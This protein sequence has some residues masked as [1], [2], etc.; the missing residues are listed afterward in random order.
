M[1]LM[2]ASRD[3]RFASVP[4]THVSIFPNRL[5]LRSEEGEP[6]ALEGK[7]RR[8]QTLGDTATTPRSPQGGAAQETRERERQQERTS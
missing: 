1:S 7:E 2:A 5:F 6:P 8:L 4:V 3:R